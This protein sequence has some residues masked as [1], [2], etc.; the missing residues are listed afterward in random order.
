MV[1][2]D[3][4]LFDF[5]STRLSNELSDKMFDQLHEAAKQ[6]GRVVHQNS[7]NQLNELVQPH[8]IDD[9]NIWIQL[10]ENQCDLLV[11]S[12]NKSSRSGFVLIKGH[13]IYYIEGKEYSWREVQ[14]LDLYFSFDNNNQ[15]HLIIESLK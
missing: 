12:I 11:V 4:T 8:K 3:T 10:G 2:I 5:T 6:T 13:G 9:A 14:A 1:G 7:F 15:D